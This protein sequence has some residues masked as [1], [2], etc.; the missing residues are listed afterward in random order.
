[1]PIGF[2]GELYIGGEGVGRGYLNASEKDA[3]RF[4]DD[5]F[6]AGRM[7]RTGDLV[8]RLPDGNLVFIGRV[9]RQVKI[10][11]F[12]IELEEIEAVLSAHPGVRHC[13]VVATGSNDRQWLGAYVE[14]A[15][16][17]SSGPAEWVAH[18]RRSLPPHMVPVGFVV[19]DRMPMTPG[20]KVDRQSL[21]PFEPMLNSGE[22]AAEPATEL[23]QKLVE[24]WRESLGVARVSTT[25]NF[26]ELGGDSLAATRLIIGIEN[27]LG[28]ELTLA[29][30]QRAPTPARM[31]LLLDRG[32]SAGSHFLELKRSGTRPP[33]ICMT[34]M[35]NEPQQLESLAR[36]MPADQP[37]WV[38]PLTDASPGPEGAVE[39]LANLAYD[40]VRSAIPS[41]DCTLG[42]YC[43]GGLVAYTVAQRF[44]GNVPLVVLFDTQTP[45]YPKIFRGRKS[46]VRQMGDWLR[47][48]AKFSLRDVGTHFRTVFR[49]ARKNSGQSSP[50]PADFPM[51]HFLAGADPC[52]TKVLED[53]RLGWRDLC[54]AGVEHFYVDA[55][56]DNMFEEAVMKTIATPLTDALH[57]ASCAIKHT[58]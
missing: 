41:G 45:G 57:R 48:H 5:P 49:L 18:L 36:R 44:G 30:L 27:R 13:A 1:V 38:L 17:S 52:S 28:Q 6:H 47:G 19:L 56:H 25:D 33:F 51:I 20:G 4:G 54:P 14:K 15:P 43:L 23:E 22:L 9:D 29:L 37:F 46:Y 8:Y 34:T 53:P 24:L 35:A 16:D 26:F 11:G 32:A 12:R 58:V 7:Y 31:A 50:A 10:G 3:S 39:R 21:P 40:L 42:G 55:H 2:V